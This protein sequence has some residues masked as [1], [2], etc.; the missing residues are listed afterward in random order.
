[1]RPAVL[2]SSQLYDLIDETLVTYLRLFTRDFSNRLLLQK[3]S[4]KIRYEEFLAFLRFFP[5]RFS[6][7][8]ELFFVLS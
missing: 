4:S 3:K 2:G 7:E 5:E 6:S 8:V 1:M